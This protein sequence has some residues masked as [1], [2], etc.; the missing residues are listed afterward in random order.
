MLTIVRHAGLSSVLIACLLA[1]SAGPTFA[2]GA[3]VIVGRASL[4][5]VNHDFM[6]CGW[7]ATFTVSGQVHWTVTIA[8]DH[9]FHFS[10]QESISYVLVIDDDPNVPDALRGV[11]WRGSNMISFATI[12]DPASEHEVTRTVQ[13][14]FEGPFRSQIERITLVVAADGTVRV[15]RF[16]SDFDANC[17][18]LVA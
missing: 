11:T 6:I 8:G 3:E 10:F 1:V 7:G 18:S 9:Q 2:T 5:D 16:V 13:T 15:D 4:D 12:V 17:E 14:A